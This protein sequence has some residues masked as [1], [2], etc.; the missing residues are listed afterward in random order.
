MKDLSK[1]D[2]YPA[3][4]RL[5]DNTQLKFGIVLKPKET[6]IF[7]EYFE[8]IKKLYITKFKKYDLNEFVLITAKLEGKSEEINH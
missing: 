8:S 7:K 5:V 2:S 4:I 3:S 6:N 1:Y